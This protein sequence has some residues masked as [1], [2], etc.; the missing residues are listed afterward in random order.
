MPHSKSSNYQKVD[1]K[2]WLYY[3][4]V[5]F[6]SLL[7]WPCGNWKRSLS[8]LH[9]PPPPLA[10]VLLL[11]QQS[12]LY[13]RMLRKWLQRI[14]S[15]LFFDKDQLEYIEI[16]C[17]PQNP[18]TFKFM[19]LVENV[20]NFTGASNTMTHAIAAVSRNAAESMFGLDYSHQIPLPPAPQACQPVA[21]T[22][23]SC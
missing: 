23:L 9:P 22:F 19:L 11:I 15:L 13:Q 4:L 8:N 16:R 12:V 5:S 18:P 2:C 10:L 6:F 1:I 3:S 17:H 20:A 21:C 7:G 14:Y